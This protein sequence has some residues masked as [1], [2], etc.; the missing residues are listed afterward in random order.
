MMW[1]LA[2]YIAIKVK[3][4]SDSMFKVKGLTMVA[5]SQLQEGDVPLFT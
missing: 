1:R 4:H 2:T 5:A 3:P